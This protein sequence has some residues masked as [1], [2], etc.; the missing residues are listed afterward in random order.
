MVKFK[1]PFLT[2][3][4]VEQVSGSLPAERSNDDR[5]AGWSYQYFIEGYNAIG[6]LGVFYNALFWN[7]GMILWIRLTQSN[8]RK[9]NKAM[10]SIAALILVLVM[11]TQTSAFIQFYWLI[12]IPGLGL[13][14]LANN[15]KIGFIK[16]RQL[17]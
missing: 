9:H 17:P 15:S 16:G 5:G 11:K 3:T 12:L 10:L 14:L 2:T 6:L 8:N 4:I 1:Y 7:L 13:L